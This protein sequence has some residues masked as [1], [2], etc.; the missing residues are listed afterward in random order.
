MT[1]AAEAEVTGSDVS[2]EWD[3]NSYKI[4]AGRADWSLETIEAW[5][6]GKTASAIHGVLGD[7]QWRELNR[8]SKPKG[9]DLPALL[10][11]ISEALGFTSPG[12]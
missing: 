10:T 12:E 5:E 11:L 8:R 1:D 2:I 3:G 6:Q 4:G 7:A 9:S